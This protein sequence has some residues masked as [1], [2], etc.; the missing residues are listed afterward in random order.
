MEK[1]VNEFILPNIISILDSSNNI[2]T[3]EFWLILIF[4]VSLWNDSE[5]S[6][7]VDKLIERNLNGIILIFLLNFNK[8]KRINLI[9]FN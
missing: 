9:L 8:K 3:I 1:T 6:D 4:I 2:W 5:R 7:Y